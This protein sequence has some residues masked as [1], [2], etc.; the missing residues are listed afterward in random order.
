[1]SFVSNP[2]NMG[3]RS[4]EFCLNAFEF[5]AGAAGMHFDKSPIYQSMIANSS[6][7]V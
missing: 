1:M 2:S 7:I 3:S 5:E 4:T 6:N